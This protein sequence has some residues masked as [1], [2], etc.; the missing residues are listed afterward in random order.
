MHA[1][2]D[3]LRSWVKNN[4][5]DAELAKS[6]IPRFWQEVV[7]DGLAGRTVIQSFENGTLRVHVPEAAWRSELSLRR[8]DL[9][10]KINA[11]AGGDLIHEI[12][13]R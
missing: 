6:R 9:R 7:G 12:I 8:E 11:L 5:L 2:S 3:L 4:R 10:T 1:L 13:I